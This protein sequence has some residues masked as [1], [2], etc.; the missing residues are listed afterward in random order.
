MIISHRHKFIFVKTRK[1]AGTSVQEAVASICGPEDIVTPTGITEGSY[2]PRHFR[3]VPTP[4]LYLRQ[5]PRRHR[6]SRILYWA[7]S[8]TRIHDHMFLDELLALPEARAWRGYFKFTVERN[9]WDKV[10]SRY[11]WKYRERPQR[12]EFER[13]VQ[14]DRLNSDFNMYSLDGKPQM[15][16]VC[17]YESLN[18]GLAEVSRIIGV[19]IPSLAHQNVST[20]GSRDYRQLYNDT[21]R[22]QVARHFAR[23]IALFG[24][25]FDNPARSQT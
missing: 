10:V 22:E 8:C 9:P 24:Y 7:W 6:T 12:P 20:R 1:T 13:F 25:K 2:Q 17:R 23:E 16:Y 5:D 11:F 14:K 15:D 19:K 21:T 4:F 18:E 3:G